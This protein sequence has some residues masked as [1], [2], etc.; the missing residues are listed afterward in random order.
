MAAV[1][2][3]KKGRLLEELRIH[4][5]TNPSIAN[6]LREYTSEKELEVFRRTD[7]YPANDNAVMSLTVEAN[8]IRRFVDDLLKTFDS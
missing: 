5:A 6:A 1:D 8:S 4:F 7:K 3:L 2:K